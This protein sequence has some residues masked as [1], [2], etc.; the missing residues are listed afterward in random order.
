[1]MR[2]KLVMPLTLGAAVVGLFLATA[3]AQ[4]VPPVSQT[5]ISGGNLPHGVLLTVVDEDAF[6]RR[7]NRPPILDDPPEI[8]GS[9]YTVTSRYWNE[10]LRDADKETA[11]ADLQASYYPESGFVQVQEAGADVWIVINQRQRAI[12]DRYIRLTLD[13]SLS[14]EPGILEVLIAAAEDEPVTVQIGDRFLDE[15]ETAE[16]W[17]VS[18]GLPRLAPSDLPDQSG[19]RD[20]GETVWLIFNLPEGRAVQMRYSVAEAT[21]VDSLGADA[22][23]VPNDWLL[24]VLGADAPRPGEPLEVGGRS[25]E[26][27]SGGGSPLWWGVLGGGGLSAIGA[28]IWL[29]RRWAS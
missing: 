4:E 21:L 25:I 12:L 23:R 11:A 8:T 26:Q 3:V 7:L 29:R 13:G 22:Y 27:N 15:V 18:E 6:V 17:R 1:M 24:S 5:R 2:L 19:S 28:A 10:V 14:K 16:F 9:V 20:G